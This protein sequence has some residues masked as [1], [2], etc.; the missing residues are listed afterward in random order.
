M[1]Y[2]YL[3]TD[4]DEDNPSPKFGAQSAGYATSKRMPNIRPTID[5]ANDTK[6]IM[7]MGERIA[8]NCLI[9]RNANETP[10]ANASML[11]ATA[12]ASTTFRLVGSYSC[13]QSSSLKD[14]IIM[15]PP[16]KARIP[17]AI[18]WSI[19]SIRWLKKLAPIHPSR[20]SKP[21]KSRS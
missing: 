2:Q 9:P 14:S 13:L 6:P 5:K 3:G 7:P 4:D 20:A 11:V 1:L 17:N 12:R 18:Q 10:T 19:L 21:G 15:R 16:R 8:E